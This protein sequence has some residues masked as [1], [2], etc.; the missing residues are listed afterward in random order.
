MGPA[1]LFTSLG[2]S[3]LQTGSNTNWVCFALPPWLPLGQRLPQSCAE[4][5]GSFVLS[6]AGPGCPISQFLWEI[7]L[8]ATVV[9]LAFSSSHLQLEKD[10]GVPGSSWFFC[11]WRQLDLQGWTQPFPFQILWHK[12]ILGMLLFPFC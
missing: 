8:G 5:N 3:L 9:A 2:S 7:T 10:P 11:H 12:Q 6:G 1:H 4:G